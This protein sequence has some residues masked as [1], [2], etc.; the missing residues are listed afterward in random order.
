MDANDLANLSVV[1]KDVSK[2]S[3][4]YNWLALELES[5]SEPL[6]FIKAEYHYFSWSTI[7]LQG[8][9]VLFVTP[10]AVLQGITEVF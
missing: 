4:L 6:N 7:Y 5:S 3:K 8:K 2:V 1:R 9:L 10:Q